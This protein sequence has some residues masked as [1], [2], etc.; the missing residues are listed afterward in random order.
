[1][2]STLATP[3]L[4]CSPSITYAAVKGSMKLAE[5][6]EPEAFTATGVS[7]ARKRPPH[8]GRTG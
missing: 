7:W 3:L 6:A 4:G 1:M 2:R 8:P 5:K